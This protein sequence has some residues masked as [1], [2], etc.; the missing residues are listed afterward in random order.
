MACGVEIPMAGG[1]E[2][3]SPTPAGSSSPRPA[4]S[5]SAPMAGHVPPRRRPHLF[6]KIDAL[7]REVDADLAER[8]LATDDADAALESAARLPRDRKAVVD[9]GGR[10]RV[11]QEEAAR[12]AKVP[13]PGAVANAWA[14]RECHDAGGAGAWKRGPTGRLAVAVARVDGSGAR[15]PGPGPQQVKESTTLEILLVCWILIHGKAK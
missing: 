5:S 4:G 10:R 15:W 13:A 14:W 9:R 3:C 8:L 12:G 6:P 11:H 7:L 1:V 2:L